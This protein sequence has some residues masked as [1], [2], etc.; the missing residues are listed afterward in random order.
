MKN[1]PSAL[2]GWQ[3]RFFQFR[4]NELRYWKNRNDF[5]AKKYASGKILFNSVRV[6]L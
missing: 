1:S 2:K 5:L 4:D 6:D 3:R